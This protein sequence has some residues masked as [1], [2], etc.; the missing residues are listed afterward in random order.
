MDIFFKHLFLVVSFFSVLALGAILIF[1]FIRGSIPFLFPT[2]EGVRLVTERVEEIK[3]NGEVYR[4]HST[5]IFIPPEAETI[6][7]VFDNQGTERSAEIALNNREKDPDRRV[8]FVRYEGGNLSRPEAYTYTLSYPGTIAALDQRIHLIV[9]EAPYNL[10]KFLGGMDWR[11]TYQKQYGIFPMILGTIFASFGAILLGVPI[12][13]LC[14]V[15]L[16]EFLPTK[17]A[18][19]VRA[20]I[21]LLAGIPSVVYGFFGL[22]VIVPLVKDLFQ[23]PSGNSLVAAI[24]VLALMI[25]PTIITITETSLRAVPHSYREA[26]LALGVSKMSTAWR[27]VLPHASSGVIAGIILGISRTVGETMAVILVAGNSVQLVKGL[28]ESIRTLTA[29][30]ALE[31]GYAEGRHSDILFSVGVVL[32]IFI[33]VL[34]GIILRIRGR[35]EEN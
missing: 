12:G 30:I 15:F 29:T 31:M 17:P 13:I 19:F 1:V 11:P 16:A 33:L 28:P 6:S 14:A 8:S 24:L 4:N 32:F 27:V 3:V 10:L 20:G 18:A 26:S 9:P 22:M 5:F 7:L 23:A 21:E 2:A 34:N 25:L 35:G